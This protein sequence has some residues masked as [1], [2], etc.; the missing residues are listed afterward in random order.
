M[1]PSSD[2]GEIAIMLWC[3]GSR[4]TCWW[5]LILVASSP[6]CRFNI[7]IYIYIVNIIF[8]Q[9]RRPIGRKARSAMPFFLPCVVTRW[10][11]QSVSLA[12]QHWNWR[13]YP[14]T[15]SLLV[16]MSLC[17]Y[18]RF[19]KFWQ[20]KPCV[21]RTEPKTLPAGE[22]VSPVPWTSGCM[23]IPYSSTHYSEQDQHQLVILHGSEKSNRFCRKWKK[24]LGRVLVPAGLYLVCTS[25]LLR[26]WSARTVVLIPIDEQQL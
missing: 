14:L 5:L 9:W 21:P 17:S 3:G 6:L 23:F 4:S 11:Q 24:K 1:Y 26:P 19:S 8:G 25:V 18:Q 16:S 20:E 15:S 13:R 2:A 22:D 7:Y 10:V 12:R